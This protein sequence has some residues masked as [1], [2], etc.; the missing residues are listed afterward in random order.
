M[1][2]ILKYHFETTMSY[3][4]SWSYENNFLRTV[5]STFTL[6]RRSKIS[7]FED[8]ISFIISLTLILYLSLQ[9]LFNISDQKSNDSLLNTVATTSNDYWFYQE[10][11][12]AY[13]M[14]GSGASPLYFFVIYQC[15][16]MTLVK[17]I[18]QC[19]TQKLTNRFENINNANTNCLMIRKET[20]FQ[21]L[22]LSISIHC[23]Q[24]LYIC[25]ELVILI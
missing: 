24:K 5:E 10:Q 19:D 21:I 8:S 7:S 15:K 14:F 23:L 25:L 13:Y 11:I 4:I 17:S 16:N 1:G 6:S 20:T 3:T 18:Y 9:L 2:C 12:V 22:Y